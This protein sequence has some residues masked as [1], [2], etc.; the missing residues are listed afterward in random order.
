MEHKAKVIFSSSSSSLHMDGLMQCAKAR[1]MNR[2]NV[3]RKSARIAFN[4]LSERVNDVREHT[5]TICFC[6]GFGVSIAFDS[7]NSLCA[8]GDQ[9]VSILEFTLAGVNRRHTD[10]S[11]AKCVRMMACRVRK[12]LYAID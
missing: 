11:N 2:F 6:L 4:M 3:L 5:Q 10:T 12:M 7:I 8:L 1:E 9:S